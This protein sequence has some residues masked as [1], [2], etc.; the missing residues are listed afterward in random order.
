MRTFVQLCT[1]GTLRSVTHALVT[2]HMDYCNAIFM[3]LPLKSIR[4]LQLL[5]NVLERTVMYALRSADITTLF[6][7]YIACFQ[8]QFKMLV[9]THEAIY[10]MGLGYLKQCLSPITSPHP[11]ISSKKDMLSDGLQEKLFC[12]KGLLLSLKSE[13][14]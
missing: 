13:W 10:I 14:L 5:Q 6:Y 4:K 12:H 11:T 8:V 3:E 1:Q 9:M 7:N 2:S